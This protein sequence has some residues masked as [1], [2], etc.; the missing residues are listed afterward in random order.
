MLKLTNS[1]NPE[2]LD[3][4]RMT[5]KENENF[6]LTSFSK[7]FYLIHQFRNQMREIRKTSRWKNQPWA[8]W[9]R[10]LE[11]IAQK[12][13]SRKWCQVVQQNINGIV[14]KF[15]V[16]WQSY[17]NFP[18]KGKQ[19]S[20]FPSSQDP[21]SSASSHSKTWKNFFQFNISP[22]NLIF[23]FF[24]V[25]LRLSYHKLFAIDVWWSKI[26]GALFRLQRFGCDVKTFNRKKAFASLF[27]LQ[28]QKNELKGC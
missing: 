27:A 26:L 24:H 9:W 11:E 21:S 7:L 17:Q 13:K 10:K 25:F 16:D 20:H 14:K 5:I 2:S 23:F 6:H 19:Q 22:K 3:Q 28:G 1:A 15:F 8:N 4:I 18:W 12:G